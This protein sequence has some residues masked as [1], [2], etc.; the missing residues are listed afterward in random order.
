MHK[1]IKSPNYPNNYPANSN[2]DWNIVNYHTNGRLKLN[3]VDFVTESNYDFVYIYSDGHYRDKLTGQKNAVTFFADR[4]MRIVFTSDYSGQR[5]G[6][7]AHYGIAGNCS[8]PAKMIFI[9]STITYCHTI[10]DL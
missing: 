10:L 7:K 6:F 3:I 4:H 2:C 1:Y 9:P 8:V 5:R